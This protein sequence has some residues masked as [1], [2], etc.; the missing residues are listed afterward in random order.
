MRGQIAKWDKKLQKMIWFDKETGL[1]ES[2]GLV[3]DEI[4][5][6]ESYATDERKI[7]TSRSKL[8]EHYKE[9]GFE[10]T[11]GDH[12][13]GKGMQD[14]KY[15]KTPREEINASVEKTLNQLKWGEAPLTEKER[16]EAGRAT[17]STGRTG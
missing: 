6:T 12:I 5:P 8:M 15:P 7:F 2:H 9:N 4:E 17:R 13:K 11:G 16:H 14:F 1:P 3:M 10:C